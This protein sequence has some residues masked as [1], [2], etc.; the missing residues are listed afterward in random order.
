MPTNAPALD[1][2]FIGDKPEPGGGGTQYRSLEDLR[3]EINA[4]P[5]PTWKPCSLPRTTYSDS[6]IFLFID[7]VQAVVNPYDSTFITIVT[8]SGTIRT[9]YGTSKEA[10]A[11]FNTI[12]KLLGVGQ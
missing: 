5:P 3:R 2:T 7:T 6:R 9:E 11:A 10:T 8:T 1:N 12:S 4:L